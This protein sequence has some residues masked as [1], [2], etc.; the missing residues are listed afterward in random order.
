MTCSCSLHALTTPTSI[1]CAPARSCKPC[2]GTLSISCSCSKW[3]TS[4]IVLARCI[5]RL[6]LCRTT[7]SPRATKG[8]TCSTSEAQKM[9]ERH[10]VS[11]SNKAYI[12]KFLM[13]LWMKL[14][15]LYVTR[16]RQLYNS[17]AKAVGH[18]HPT[19]GLFLAVVTLLNRKIAP[20]H[21]SR[22]RKDEDNEQRQQHYPSAFKGTRGER[23]RRCSNMCDY[24]DL[25][26]AQVS[27]SQTKVHSRLI[28]PIH[29]SRQVSNRRTLTPD[30]EIKALWPSSYLRQLI[31][32]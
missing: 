4:L 9:K 8:T 15:V 20:L 25:D 1:L 12:D 29:A 21:K 24:H 17:I 13:P 32:R 3:T 6:P 16:K 22:P 30:G 7:Q 5:P 18:T 27:R 10:G 14:R 11:V 26:V 23:P 19:P 31:S 2:C 28:F